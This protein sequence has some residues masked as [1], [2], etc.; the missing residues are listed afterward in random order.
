MTGKHLLVA[1]NNIENLNIVNNFYECYAQPT[2]SYILEAT[3]NTH[4]LWIA[5]F[6]LGRKVFH[7]N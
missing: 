5:D 1:S 7:P 4:V 3:Y 6:S 2:D